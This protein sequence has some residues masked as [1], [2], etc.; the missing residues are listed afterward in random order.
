MMFFPHPN[1]FL[2]T[3]LSWTSPS[4]S[5]VVLSPDDDRKRREKREGGRTEHNVMWPSMWSL[6]SKIVFD[7]EGC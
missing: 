1:G 4:I 2:Y 7:I 6:L 3:F 5:F